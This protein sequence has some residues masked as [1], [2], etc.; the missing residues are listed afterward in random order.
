M[1]TEAK[2]L[3]ASFDALPPQEQS[4]VIAE[5]QRRAAQAK[6]EPCAGGQPAEG[7][8]NLLPPDEWLAAFRQWAR[9]DRRHNPNVDDSRESI[10]AD[11]GE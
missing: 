2:N 3:L 5:L 7:G 11:R 1:S 4:S 6:G 8:D 10:Y 9:K